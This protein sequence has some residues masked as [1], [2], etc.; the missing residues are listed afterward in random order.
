MVGDVFFPV[1]VDW[2]EIRGLHTIA[3]VQDLLRIFDDPV[4]SLLG[5]SLAIIGISFAVLMM[6]IALVIL[7]TFKVI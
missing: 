5:C 2:K 1:R 3:Q 6:S 4:N 7:I